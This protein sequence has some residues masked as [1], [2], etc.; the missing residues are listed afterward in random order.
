MYWTL[1]FNLSIPLIYLLYSYKTIGLSA[2]SFLAI[3]LT[4]DAEV[5]W[6]VLQ[7]PLFYTIWQHKSYCFWN[8][9]HL[10]YPWSFWLSLKLAYSHLLSIFFELSLLLSFWEHLFWWVYKYQLHFIPPFS[11]RLARLGWQ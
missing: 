10:S 3:F 7:L 11:K 8:I 9:L 2:S 1:W 6:V 5:W 4:S